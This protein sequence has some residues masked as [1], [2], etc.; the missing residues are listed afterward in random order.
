MFLRSCSVI[1]IAML[2]VLFLPEASFAVDTAIG[3]MM[4]TVSGWMLG[5][6]GKGL[7]TLGMI[8][9]GIL[10]LLGKISWGLVIIHAVGG[11]L[12][13]GASSLVTA[14]GTAGTGC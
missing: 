14:L 5:N 9:L 12:I 13:V 3:D 6:T 2:L 7:A 4:C 8:M 1:V 11:V 10:A